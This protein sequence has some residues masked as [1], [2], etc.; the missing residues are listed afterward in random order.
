MC[1]A[2]N[3]FT[4][5]C[6]MLMC[7]KAEMEARRKR[8]EEEARKRKEEEEKKRKEEEEKERLRLVRLLTHSVRV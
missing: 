7:R 5:V 8:E 6:V 1:R 3:L 2:R 4:V